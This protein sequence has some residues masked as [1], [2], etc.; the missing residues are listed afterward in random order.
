MRTLYALGGTFI[1]INPMMT[2]KLILILPAA[3]G[4]G[5]YLASNRNEHQK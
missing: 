4:P 3:L 5:I 2:T 1:N